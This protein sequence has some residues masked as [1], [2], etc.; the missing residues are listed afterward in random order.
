MDI[1]RF[2]FG[3]RELHRDLGSWLIYFHLHMPKKYSHLHMHL[4][5]FNSV[6]GNDN[7]LVQ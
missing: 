2:V 3:R 7:K 6:A 4:I 5:F 1:V